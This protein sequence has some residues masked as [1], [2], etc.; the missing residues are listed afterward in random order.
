MF[1]IPCF[2]IFLCLFLWIASPLMAWIST[3]FKHQPWLNSLR[4]SICL[5]SG[6]SEQFSPM[7]S[8]EQSPSGYVKEESMPPWCESQNFIFPLSATLRPTNNLILQCLY[9][10]V[11]CLSL[12]GTRTY[13]HGY[14]TKCVFSNVLSSKSMFMN[15]KTFGCL[16][17]HSSTECKQIDKLKWIG[18]FSPF[19]C[20]VIPGEFHWINE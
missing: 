3:T 19:S 14:R 15:K 2:L 4:F 13:V 9:D 6:P 8:S 10:R 7:A 16:L 18:A 12:T 20:A 17:L 1:V 11:H 5:M